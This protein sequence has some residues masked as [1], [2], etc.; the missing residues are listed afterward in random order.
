MKY[1]KI[2]SF[3][4]VDGKSYTTFGIEAVENGIV[5]DTVEDVSPDERAVGKLA[6][7]CNKYELSVEHLRDIIEDFLASE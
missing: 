4:E 3:A 1:I 2:K 7:D 6:A 5:I